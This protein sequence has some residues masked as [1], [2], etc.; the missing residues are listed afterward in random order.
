MST[1]ERPIARRFEPE[2]F[3]AAGVGQPEPKPPL[4][5]IEREEAITLDE[6]TQ[7]GL[8]APAT[9]GSKRVRVG[10]RAVG[11]PFNVARTGWWAV[12]LRSS[13]G[14]AS[15]LLYEPEHE[16]RVSGL[17]RLKRGRARKEKEQ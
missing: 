11:K 15:T 13:F 2:E 10:F 12:R 16:G 3:I 1:E 5:L 14:G 8:K 6:L 9:W 7:K 17:L 4:R